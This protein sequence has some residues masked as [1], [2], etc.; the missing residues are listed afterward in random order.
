MRI[1]IVQSG[2]VFSSG[3]IGEAIFKSLGKQENIWRADYNTAKSLEAARQW[4][5]TRYL[6]THEPYT[7]DSLTELTSGFILNYCVEDNIDTVL[8]MHGVHIH[9]AH[10]N[11]LNKLNITTA[12]W[13]LDDPHEFDMNKERARYYKLVFT[14]DK[15]TVDKYERPTFYVPTAVDPEIFCPSDG[16]SE[17]P[18]YDVLVYGSF[19]PERLSFLSKL[20]QINNEN[21][22]ILGFGRTKN[23]IKGVDWVN[24]PYL[25]KTVTPRINNCR[26]VLDMARDPFRS[27]YGATNQG[28]ILPC[29]INPRIYE[30]AVCGRLPITNCN[31]ELLSEVFGL[32]MAQQIHYNTVEEAYEKIQY[33]MDNPYI[34]NSVVGE[35]KNTVLRE[36]T[37]DNRTKY[38]VGKLREFAP[39]RIN[40]RAQIVNNTRKALTPL[41]DKNYESNKEKL[42]TAPSIQQFKNLGGTGIIVSNGP[43]FA[44]LFCCSGAEKKAYEEL[45]TKAT[46]ISVNSGFKELCRK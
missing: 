43:G 14:N 25:W 44:K 19:Y 45:I 40:R 9:P 1:L 18:Y 15:N 37:Y 22:S 27:A 16:K 28:E 36:H 6:Y 17:V 33:F 4:L 39:K 13:V 42:E 30:A 26:I 24:S 32:E 46:V 41:W 2:F 7:N 23:E 31:I 10:V 3:E 20:V 21:Y 29:N 38:I 34:Y 12:L 8:F 5:H 11:H 35:L